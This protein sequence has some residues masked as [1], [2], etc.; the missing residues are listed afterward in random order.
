MVDQFQFEIVVSF[1]CSTC[2]CSREEK[3]TV[4][5]PVAEPSGSQIFNLASQQDRKCPVC[6]CRIAPEDQCAIR[7]AGAIDTWPSDLPFR[8]NRIQKSPT[9][10]ARE[11]LRGLASG[12]SDAYE[13]YRGLYHLWC[14]QNSAVQELRPLFRIPGIEPDGQLS[15]TE[16]FK[17]QVRS[18]ANAI[19]ASLPD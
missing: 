13:T 14:T 15:V 19:L 2:L 6:G 9:Q 12:S 8:W 10:T 11:L 16:D 7:P 1:N 3:T 17:G 18:L 4:C 5:T